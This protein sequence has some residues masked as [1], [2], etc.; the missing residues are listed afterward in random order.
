MSGNNNFTS[1][2]PIKL[3]RLRISVITN[4]TTA[5][6]IPSIKLFPEIPVMYDTKYSIS[7]ACMFSSS[8]RKNRKSFI[9]IIKRINPKI[10]QII[11]TVT[12]LV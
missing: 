4:T 9:L 12:F 1:P 8:I 6:D 7:K 10:H 2:P 5:V 11:K 3:K